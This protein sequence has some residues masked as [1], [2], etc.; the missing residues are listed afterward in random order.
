MGES[1]RLYPRN[2]NSNRSFGANRR[3]ESAA[4]EVLIANYRSLRIAF[5]QLFLDHLESF[6]DFA[7][8]IREVSGQRRSLRIDHHIYCN[9]DRKITQ[10]D[11]L[12]QAAPDSISL[13]RAAQRLAHCEAN[14]RALQLFIRAAQVKSGHMRR[15]VSPSLLIN[16][17]KV[18]MP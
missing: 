6:H 7:L 2:K 16:S 15:E 4:S 14:S 3:P 11:G 13:N 10:P 5:L 18:R 1:A 17:L 12:T 8:Q 9:R